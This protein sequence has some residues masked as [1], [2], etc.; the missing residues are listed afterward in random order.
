MKIGIFGGSFNPIHCGH[1]QLARQ[2]RHELALDEVWLVVSPLNPF[3]VQSTDL[4][5][6]DLRLLMVRTAVAEVAGLEASDVEFAL[7]KPSYMWNTL[8]Y[9]SHAHPEH[10][11]TLL[12][13]ADNWQSF[14]RWAHWQDILANYSVAIYPR[15]EYPIDE[16]SLPSDV[17]LLHAQL[18]PV[19][20]TAIRQL[21]AAG[22][23]ITGLVPEATEPMVR[24]LYAPKKP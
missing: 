10:S 6:D 22:K 5:A 20:S 2:L 24:Q 16:S 19:S 14:E 17:C 3:K 15:P 4:L 1:V 11:Y 9:L 13:G 21:V 23:P 12:I 8:Q 7:P 18:F